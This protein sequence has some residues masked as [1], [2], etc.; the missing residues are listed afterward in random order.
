MVADASAAKFQVVRLM[1]STFQ[2]LADVGH[3]VLLVDHASSYASFAITGYSGDP[4]VALQG[5]G[6]CW[7]Y[8]WA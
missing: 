3:L 6:M 2:S 1:L 8:W 5:N 4:C 7:T